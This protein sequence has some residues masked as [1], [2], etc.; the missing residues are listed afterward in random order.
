MKP[1]KPVKPNITHVPET[2]RPQSLATLRTGAKTTDHRTTSPRCTAPEALVV[3]RLAR[4]PPVG[5][6]GYPAIT[7]SGHS[8]CLVTRFGTHSRASVGG[9]TRKRSLGNPGTCS[10]L[11]Q[12]GLTPRSRRG[13]TSKRQARAAA[14]AIIR[15]AGLAFC[16][17]S[18]L[19]SNVRPVKSLV[20]TAS[21]RLAQVGSPRKLHRASAHSG[22]F[23][24]GDNASAIL[25]RCTRTAIRSS[26]CPF[27]NRSYMGWSPGAQ[28]RQAAAGNRARMARPL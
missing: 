26:N 18:R 6:G 1:A 20:H 16:C 23:G 24:M 8:K 13:P 27:L 12:R 17:R 3:I 2:N 14:Q 7:C 25:V 22:I 15:S 11:A 21:T 10:H 19:S 4:L 5:A 28:A 9:H